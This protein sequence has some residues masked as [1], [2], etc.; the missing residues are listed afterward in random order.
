MLKDVGLKGRAAVSEG[1]STGVPRDNAPEGASAPPK[2]SRRRSTLILG[3]AVF[4]SVAA[5]AAALMIALQPTAKTLEYGRL[6]APCAMV[7]RATLAR[8][9]PNPTGTPEVL[10]SVGTGK[11]EYCKWSSTAGGE[12]RTVV[13]DVTVFSS[14]GANS[15]ARQFYTRT[16]P[17]L[18]CHCP[19]TAVSTRSV[20]GLGDQATA[21]F[22]T[23]GPDAADISTSGGPAPGIILLVDSRNAYISLSYGVAVTGTGAALP[24]DAAKLTWMI[25]AAR[26]IL[27]DLARPAAVT[28]AP[29]SAEPS[30]A[31][32]RDRAG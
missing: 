9:L 19:G 5:I 7:S 22:V 29:V 31:G 17:V 8:Y 12:D 20:P 21:L 27:A 14:S 23:A 24:A 32:S 2:T 1:P 28:A 6:P 11:Q 25:A 26:G 18:A 30:Y 3:G 10:P 16:L 15:E 13:S 4:I